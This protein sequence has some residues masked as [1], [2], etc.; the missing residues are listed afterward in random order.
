MVSAGRA[1]AGVA[2]TVAA[3]LVLVIGL[4]IVLRGRGGDSAAGA[5]GTGGAAAIAGASGGPSGSA[6]GAALGPQ[7]SSPGAPRAN[8]LS[9]AAAAWVAG[10]SGTVRAAVYDVTTGQ[11]WRLGDGPVQAEA[12]VVKLDILEA[13]L[14]R[15]GVSGLSAADKSL[16]RSMIED[17]DN[18]A[19]TSLWDEAG[20]AVGLAAYN[21]RAGLTRTAPS[22]C[23]TCA[24]F[25]WPGWGLTTTVPYDQL[26]LL[27]QL[28]L[29]GERPL[30]SHAARSYALSLLEHIA[31]GQ[32]WGVSAGVPA[33]VKVALKNGWLPLDGVNSNWQ[34]NSVGWISGDGR[35]YLIA[36]FSTGTATEKYGIQTINHLSQLV[37]SA[38]R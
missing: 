36:V 23:V 29:P 2:V 14:A 32:R 27:R 35:D 34:V 1:V 38:M 13:L 21:D 15:G 7:G 22:A 25:P 16:A 4:F 26:V 20:G 31:L 8:P 6:A 5:A 37:W 30:L 24:G 18:D 11:S 17:S 28:V 19:A 9:G 12:S 3:A 33:G 10:R